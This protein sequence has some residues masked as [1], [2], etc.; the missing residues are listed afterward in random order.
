MPGAG[1]LKQMIQF[2]AQRIM[3]MDAE[4][5]CAAAYAGADGGTS[6]RRKSALPPGAS[7]DPPR[8]FPKSASVSFYRHESAHA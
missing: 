2:V 6:R 7:S 4:S 3:E 1:L 8:R 5:L